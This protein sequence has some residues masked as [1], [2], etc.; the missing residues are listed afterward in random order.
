M[1]SARVEPELDSFYRGATLVQDYRPWA[2][3]LQAQGHTVHTSDASFEGFD[4]VWVF[5][6]RQ[7]QAV[8]RQIARGLLAASSEGT[9]RITLHNRGGASRYEKTLRKLCPDLQSTSKHKCRVMT[10]RR[11]DVQDEALLH[12]WVEDGA[13]RFLEELDAWTQPG[14]FSWD[15]FDKGSQV[16]REALP[17]DQLKGTVVDLGAGLGLLSRPLA[18]R[19]KVRRLHLVEADHR[20]LNACRRNVEAWGH[21]ELQ[22]TFHWLD[23]TTEPLP[24]KSADVVVMNPPF[25]EGDKASPAIGQAFIRAAAGVLRTKGQL[26]MV[27]NA[28]LPYERVLEDHFF[29][30]RK[31]SESRGFKVLVAYK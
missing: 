1:W 13:P 16:L 25:H 4:E 27:A 5:P 8:L 3:Q 22:A 26:W 19:S 21:P 17:V 14:A 29:K 2:V 24:I 20:A 30:V 11:S 12:Q 18:G 15:R 10:V 31:V 7:K 9:V 6:G 28:R 23:V